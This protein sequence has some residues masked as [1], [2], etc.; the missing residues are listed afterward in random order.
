[1][2]KLHCLVRDICLVGRVF[3]LKVRV[4]HAPFAFDYTCRKVDAQSK[5][6]KKIKI[7]KGKIVTKHSFDKPDSSFWGRQWSVSA[8]ATQPAKPRKSNVLSLMNI[9]SYRSTE[10]K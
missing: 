7:S 10:K 8:K 6:K 3:S 1:M 9:G 4:T 2:G 5:K